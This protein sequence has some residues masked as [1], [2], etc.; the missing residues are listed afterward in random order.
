VL[1]AHCPSEPER[2]RKRRGGSERNYIEGVRKAFSFSS[3]FENS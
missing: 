1:T 2:E 3:G